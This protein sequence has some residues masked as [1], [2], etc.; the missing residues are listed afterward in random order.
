MAS[1]F[2]DWG[3]QYN[4]K[5]FF[6]LFDQG[7]LAARLGAYTTYDRRGAVV[8]QY[9]FEDGIGDV[10]PDETGAGSVVALYNQIW[11]H[12]PFC[13]G[14][15]CGP[16]I[17]RYASVERRQPVP[18]PPRVGFQASL[19]CGAN[20]E[21]VRHFIDYYDGTTRWYANLRINAT[22]GTLELFADPA[23]V[24]MIDP[25]IPVLSSNL[26]FA[27]FKLVVDLSTH[28]CVR[29]I[30]D[31]VEYDLSQYA[32]RALADTS[33]PHIRG[34]TMNISVTGV[35]SS[36]FVDNLII[37]AAEPPNS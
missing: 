21:Q 25:N 12:P 29:A 32:L 27:H 9:G 28:M 34:R 10:G 36:V 13:V 1:D 7:E 19:R 6:P 33:A 11:E 22:A 5:Q 16:A 8:W 4:D 35:S 31:A 23:V 37:T 30:M 15:T 18:Q 20:V 14:L 3:G 24:Y 26:F 17:D 2:P